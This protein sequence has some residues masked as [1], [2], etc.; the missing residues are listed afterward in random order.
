[1]VKILDT[2]L[3]DGSYVVDFKFTATDAAIIASSLD[4][5]GIEFIEIGHGLGLGAT[6]NPKMKA[7]ASDEAY[8]EAVSSTVTKS[9]WGMFYIPG[10]GTVE[11]IINSSKFKMDFIR[12]GIDISDPAAAERSIKTAKD[13]GMFVA[14]NLMKTYAF[15]PEE[16]GKLAVLLEDYGSDMI[17]IVDSAGGMLPEDI[18][19]YF[20]EIRLRSIIPLGFHGHNNLGLAISN[21]LKAVQLGA[22]IVDTSIR[23]MGRSAGNA[24]TEIMLLALQRKGYSHQIDITKILNMAENLI[25]PFLKNYNQVDSIG[26]ISGYAQFHSSFLSIVMEYAYKHNVDPRE[27]IIRLTQ[28]DKLEAPVELV[29][30]LAMNLASEKKTSSFNPIR[31][32]PIYKTP[33]LISNPVKQVELIVE[34]LTI[35]SGKYAKKTVINFVQSS[36]PDLDCEISANINEGANYLIASAEIGSKFDL[37]KIMQ[38]IDGKIDY[39]LIDSDKRNPQS[40]NIVKSFKSNYIKSQTLIYSDLNV[41]SNSVVALVNQLDEATEGE[42]LIWGVNE[43]TEF[44]KIK[45]EFSGRKVV[46]C[47]VS[48]YKEKPFNYC[49]VGAV[50]ACEKIPDEIVKTLYNI[51]VFVDATIGCLSEAAVGEAYENNLVVYRV[52]MYPLIHA[53]ALAL[54][55]MLSLVKNNQGVSQIC[56]I[57]VA[58]GGVVAK[59]G[60]VIIDSIRSPSKVYGIA[61][62]NGYLISPNNLGIDD[63]KQIKKIENHIIEKKIYDY[64]GNEYT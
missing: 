19:E 48:D 35:L 53:E 28:V 45:F 49:E 42:I 13:Q 59:K 60:T 27:L 5:A 15:T 61:N 14:A 37:T 31:E 40:L 43:L 20:S 12:I 24:V 58:A 44:C 3:R 25:D 41:W 26:I 39:L 34:Q 7:A 47:R 64:V 30:Q 38:L 22:E 57:P 11:D 62:G 8:M 52:D 16:I 56:G 36:K 2:T 10:I 6:R 33:V 9:K 21:S 18:E 4:N 63:H 17:C 32:L 1:M 51:P 50:I 54:V 55:G 23:G 29:N 46:V